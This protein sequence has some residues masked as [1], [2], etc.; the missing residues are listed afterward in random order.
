MSDI[1]TRA[2]LQWRIKLFGPVQVTTPGG[3]AVPLRGKKAGELLARIALLPGRMHSRSDLADALWGDSDVA[4]ARTRLRQEI[5]A[6]RAQFPA[7]DDLAPLL[8]VSPDHLCIGPNTETDAARFN[9]CCAGALQKANI[10]A[11]M[12]LLKEACELYAGPLLCEY[13]AQWVTPERYRFQRLYEQAAYTFAEAQLELADFPAAEETLRLLLSHNP[14]HE[15][16]H[17]ALMRL[18]SL[19]GQPER[20]RQQ[21]TELEDAQ[22]AAGEPPPTEET[23]RVAERLRGDAISRALQKAAPPVATPIDSNGSASVIPTGQVRRQ[24]AASH[25]EP[26][27]EPRMSSSVPHS[28]RSIL[29]AAG[30][31]G[32]VLLIGSVALWASKTFK[33]ARREPGP[34]SSVLADMPPTFAYL[35]KGDLGEKTNSEGV[36]IAADTTGIYATGLVQTETEDVDILTLKLSYKGELLW[37]RRYSS[38]EHD[39]DRPASLCLDAHGAVYVAGETY[40]PAGEGHPGEWRLALL[41]YDTAGKRLWAIRSPVPVQNGE[42]I[43]VIDDR[44]GGCYIGG[45]AV[46]KGAQA[47]LVLHY[48]RDGRMLGQNVLTSGTRASFGQFAC[49]GDG[50]LA[51]C[52]TTRR[53]SGTEDADHDW[54]VASLGPDCHEQWRAFVDGG[55]HGSDAAH[56]VMLDSGGN[57]VVGGVLNTGDPARGGH[58]INLAVVKFSQDGTRLWKKVADDTGP[59]VFAEGLGSNQYGDVAV[60]GTIE[61]NDGTCGAVVV[62]YNRHGQHI[63]T[64]HYAPAPGYR[65]V[66]LDSVILDDGLSIGYLGMATSGKLSDLR[67]TSAIIYG[68]RSSEGRPILQSTYRAVPETLNSANDWAPAHGGRFAITGQSELAPNKRSLLVLFY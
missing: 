22:K 6:L 30:I 14:L 35:D 40:V 21:L 48:D 5:A 44:Q 28:N 56:N 18:Y 47:I 15:Q 45:T 3:A 31:L 12:T 24:P 8:I 2:G 27:T 52:G 51:L 57:V 66:A 46:V 65:S 37:R 59:N 17:V 26:R 53:K 62:R 9:E 19:C 54:I 58:G 49:T 63:E 32:L 60:G 11:K 68:W 1:H 67:K 55:M 20:V 10:A 33:N 64:W 25:A 23:R 34:V 7:S 38:P 29:V 61:H 36:A 43:Q 39:C 50:T 13:D 4:S 42:N 16:A 41:K